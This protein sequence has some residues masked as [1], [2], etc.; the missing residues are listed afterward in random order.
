MI[1]ALFLWGLRSGAVRGEPRLVRPFCSRRQKRER[2]F[3]PFGSQPVEIILGGLYFL[4]PMIGSSNESISIVKRYMLCRC[5]SG[6]GGMGTRKPMIGEE[7]HSVRT[8]M[9]LVRSLKLI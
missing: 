8:S 9:M 6:K 5:E 2:F 7:G 3:L 1:E 4:M